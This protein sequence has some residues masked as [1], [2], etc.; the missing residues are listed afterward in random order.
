M[1]LEKAFIKHCI[2]K[3]F[4][5]NK[6]QIHTITLL[7]KFYRNNKE[8]FFNFFKKILNKSKKN[9]FYLTGD[10]GVGKTMIMD[11]FFK[12]QKTPKQRYHF[13]EFM[14]NFHD[15]RH[16][17]EKKNKDNSIE[18][19][20]KELKK[21]AN[22]IFFDEF[23]VTN[24]V[25]AMILGKLFEI[26]IEENIIIIMTS[27]TKIEDLYKEG[28]QREQ[29]LPFIF[30]MNKFS[31]KHELIID[32][33]TDYRK[34][35]ITK[36]KRYLYPLNEDT[37]FQLNQLF[38]KLTKNKKISN[39]KILVRGREIQIENFYEGI[40]KFKFSDLCEKNIGGEDYIKIAEHCDFVF[41]ENVSQFDDENKNT[42]QRFITLIDIFYDK[43]IP[44]LISSNFQLTELCSSSTMSEPFKRT[45]SRIYELTSPDIYTV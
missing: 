39:K 18:I 14:I 3:K 34:I 19:F 24:I 6:R 16:K 8:S 20:V 45:K 40:A 4:L 42:Q 9:A 10:V 32:H 23:Q 36:L 27:N 25:D 33:V 17:Y 13:N 5:E 11:F 2:E 38:R 12:N 29:F 1:N 21:K 30:L 43:R 41:I 35:G 15:F 44:L 28:L 31:T 22:L 37:N 26:I 7:D